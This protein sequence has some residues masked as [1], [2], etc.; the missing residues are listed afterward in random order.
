VERPPTPES[1]DETPQYVQSQEGS[2]NGGAFSRNPL[3]GALIRPTIQIEG[4]GKG[5]GGERKQAWRR[6]QDDNDDNEQWI[7][8]GGVYGGRTQGAEQ[9]G[10]G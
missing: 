9:D 6:V 3:L 4:K 8:D 5:K 10:C 1:E 2:A 7:L